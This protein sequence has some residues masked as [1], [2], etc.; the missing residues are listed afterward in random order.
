MSGNVFQGGWSPGAIAAR[1]AGFGE[2]LA[3]LLRTLEAHGLI[4]VES[5]STPWQSSRLAYNISL[6]GLALLERLAGEAQDQ[7]EPGLPDAG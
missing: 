4:Q 6:P 1:D 5:G 2:A 7:Q 3:A